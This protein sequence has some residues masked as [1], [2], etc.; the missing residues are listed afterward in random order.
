MN[1]IKV[2]F[3]VPGCFYLISVSES[4]MNQFERRGLGF[5]NVFDSSFDDVLYV[6]YLDFERARELI[7]RRVIGMPVPF[8]SLCYCVSGGLAR[9]LIRAC[10]DALDEPRKVGAELGISD[11]CERMLRSDLK[12][13]LRALEIEAKGV[14][15]EEEVT[16]FLSLLR[17][18]E[19]E[20]IQPGALVGGAGELMV[21]PSGPKAD[22]P[23]PI[24]A[25]R[26]TL[27]RLREELATYLLY[28]ATV[29]QLFGPNFDARMEHG[30]FDQVA[31]ARQA[32]AVNPGLARKLLAQIRTEHG[33]LPSLEM[34]IFS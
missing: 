33:M 5:R 6:D 17:Q 28:C 18:I 9:D 12:L 19:E 7:K 16:S 10:R 8:T 23:E 3:G 21:E 26:R 1:E 30:S 27:R 11:V 2:I 34:P 15:L 22:E 25:D 20:A 24:A 14:S 4:A 29:R 32:F 13:K 31:K